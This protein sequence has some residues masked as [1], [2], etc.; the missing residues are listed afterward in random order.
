[1]A[2]Q[3]KLNFFLNAYLS[4]FFLILSPLQVLSKEPLQLQLLNNDIT[5]V[6]SVSTSQKTF[7]IRRGADSG[8]TLGQ[9]S[10]FS[11]KNIS[12]RMKAIEVSRFFSLW[13]TSDKRARIPFLKND[14]IN[15]SSKI[16]QITLEIPVI[17]KNEIALSRSTQKNHYWIARMALSFTLTESISDIDSNSNSLRNGYQFELYRPQ[18]L[19][20]RV[21]WAWGIRYDTE[22]VILRDSN[23]Q[24]PTVRLLGMTEFT[25]NFPTFSKTNNHFYASLGAGIGS[26]STNINDEISSGYSIVAPI[27]RIGFNKAYSHNL[28]FLIEGT[29]ETIST[30][31]VFENGKEQTTN[32]LNL[33]ITF[34]VKF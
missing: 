22:A 18:R 9:E 34:G 7:V 13:K 2:I 14:F 12:L 17:N 3:F 28:L 21:D 15:Y 20:N 1:M 23:L 33:K 32:M 6:Q 24:I 11:T 5:I 27:V 26:S 29:G 31:E 8:V 10:L 30:K 16:D 4:I 25:Y 19:F